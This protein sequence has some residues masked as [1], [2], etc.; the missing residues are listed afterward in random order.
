M[1]IFYKTILVGIVLLIALVLIR[2]FKGPGIYDTLN[3]IFVLGVD[4]II[5]LLL[6]GVITD[7]QEM[8]VDIAFSYGI[9]GFLSTVII[10][11]F[12]GTPDKKKV[13]EN[14]DIEERKDV[15]SE[16]DATSEVCLKEKSG[17]ENI[18]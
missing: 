3:G 10:A 13:T 16:A 1:G 6:I 14:Q 2:V 4:V 9:L 12:L 8:Y 17:E 15:I 18:R 5:L 7:R 11:R